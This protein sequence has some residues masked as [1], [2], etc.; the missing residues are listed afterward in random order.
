MNNAKY[1]IT[2][3]VPLGYEAYAELYDP[4][5]KEINVGAGT[6]FSYDSSLSTMSATVNCIV[7]Q[8]GKTLERAALK[9]EF[10][11]SPESIRELTVENKIILS[12]SLLA[13]LASVTYNTLR[14]IV[15]A[16]SQGT[17][18]NKIILPIFDFTPFV[19][20]DFVI[21]I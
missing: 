12:Q 10:L 4:E 14:G 21:E 3:I 20:D 11:F 1:K 7:L 17:R 16:V 18:L 2:S 6:S 19:G 15:F 8:A 13:E 5:D 9:C